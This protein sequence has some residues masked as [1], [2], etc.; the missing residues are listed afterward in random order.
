M[1]GAVLPFVTGG[2][3]GLKSS[4]LQHSGGPDVSDAN[5]ETDDAFR[6]A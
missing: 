3:P 5:C 2:L 1:E 4:T 6:Q